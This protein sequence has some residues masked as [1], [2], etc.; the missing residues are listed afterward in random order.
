MDGGQRNEMMAL[1]SPMLNRQPLY[2]EE[3][4]ST[5]CCDTA[6]HLISGMQCSVENDYSLRCNGALRWKCPTNPSVRVPIDPC[7]PNMFFR[8]T[9]LI[10]RIKFVSC[11]NQRFRVKRVPACWT[12][13]K[14]SVFRTM[15]RV[16]GISP[17]KTNGCRRRPLC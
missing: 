6:L 1:T 12:Q 4:A 10:K 15:N 9:T 5:S 2:E 7:T 14:P 8:I 11:E 17:T 3:V 13:V 16:P